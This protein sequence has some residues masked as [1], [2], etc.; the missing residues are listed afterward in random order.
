MA[1]RVQSIPLARSKE[2]RAF[3]FPSVSSEPTLLESPRN[4][5]TR[6]M[7]PLTCSISRDNILHSCERRYYFQYL[8]N[9]RYNSKNELHRD[10]ALLKQLKSIPAWAGDCFHAAVG[11]WANAVRNGHHLPKKSI[12]ERLRQGMEGQWQRSISSVGQCLR[13]ADVSCRLFEHEYGIEMPVGR[14][15]GAITEASNWIESFLAWAEGTQLKI[16]AWIG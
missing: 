7:P 13:G 4:P 12:L 5:G 8:V 3:L 2:V 11:R 16:S 1:E 14:L 6:L 15:E 9:A 10:V